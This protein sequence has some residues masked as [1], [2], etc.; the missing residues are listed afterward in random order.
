[1]NVGCVCIW[2]CAGQ[3]HMYTHINTHSVDPN[4][5]Y[6]PK[7]GTNLLAVAT[8]SSDWK[9][10]I[11]GFGTLLYCVCNTVRP[12]MLVHYLSAQDNF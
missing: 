7:S 5:D 4:T 3:M 6:R 2:V 1:M 8:L 11:S 12:Q 10:I 9:P